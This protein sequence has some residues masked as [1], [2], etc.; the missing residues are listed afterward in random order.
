MLP[1]IAGCGQEGRKQPG[2]R[3]GAIVHI[4]AMLG[5]CVLTSVKKLGKIMVI[6]E[7]GW[8]RLEAERQQGS[9][10]HDSHRQ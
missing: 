4:L 3:A 7:K 1:Q 2:A 6:L 5:V 10:I 8:D 9:I